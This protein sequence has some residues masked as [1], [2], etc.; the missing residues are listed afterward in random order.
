MHG[1][2]QIH[3]PRKHG[4]VHGEV[5]APEMADKKMNDEDMTHGEECLELLMPLVH[6]WPGALVLATIL[7]PGHMQKE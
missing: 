6:N 1:G 5:M 7:P 2:G 3:A 4:L